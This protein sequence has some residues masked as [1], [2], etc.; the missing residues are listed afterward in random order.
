[1]SFSMAIDLEGETFNLTVLV[2]HRSLDFACVFAN[3][4]QGFI[5]FNDLEEESI[6]FPYFS[7]FPVT[8]S[9][10]GGFSSFI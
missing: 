2:R 7:I 4:V 5:Y 8:L 1:M 10:G 6:I 3:N 9:E